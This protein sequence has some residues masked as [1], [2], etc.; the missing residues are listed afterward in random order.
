MP[1]TPDEERVEFAWRIEQMAVQIDKGRLD[2]EKIR[3][4]I[5]LDRKRFKV[6]VWGM[7]ITAIGVVVAAFAAGGAWVHYTGR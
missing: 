1:L 2:I 7:L 4:D 5:D 3:Q 6:Q